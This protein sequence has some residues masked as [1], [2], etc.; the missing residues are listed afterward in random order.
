[1]GQMFIKRIRTPWFMLILLA[2]F[3]HLVGLIHIAGLFEVV[4]AGVREEK[5]AL[6]DKTK[7]EENVLGETSF[8]VL[9]EEMRDE[10]KKMDELLGGK[11]FG[12]LIKH[13]L[14]LEKSDSREV[15]K[16]LLDAIREQFSR[17][18]TTLVKLFILGVLSAF[19]AEFENPTL[20]QYVGDTGYFAIYTIMLSIFLI[21]FKNLYDVALT[22]VTVMLQ[23]VSALTPIYVSA[24]FLAGNMKTAVGVYSFIVVGIGVVEWTICNVIFPVS[25]FYF[26]LQMLNYSMKEQRFA[27]LASFLKSVVIWVLRL[28]FG[29]ITGM[30]VVQCLLLPATDQAR[31]SNFSKSLAAIPGLGASARAL[32]GTL[33][34]SATVLKN[35]VGVAGM[36]VLLALVLVPAIKLLFGIV[37]YQLMAALLQPVAHKQIAALLG[38]LS[39]S[40]KLLFQGLVTATVLF[41]VCIAII[42]AATV[43]GG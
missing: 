4:H 34:Q 37:S 13:L 21:S 35:A 12:E 26:V 18:K 9:T 19:I 42:T 24:L 20:K 27:R 28:L 31:S 14:S 39:S 3:M 43:S 30:Q 22:G 17:E 25:Y 36:L 33:L 1:M 29:V 16:L 32:T 6:P 40:I 11:S 7:A 23:G 10:F 8:D 41:L 38:S 5:E 15:G 2:G